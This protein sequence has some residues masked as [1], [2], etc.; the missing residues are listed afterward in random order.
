M[1]ENAFSLIE[2][3]IVILIIGILVAG[4]TQGSRLV[5]EMKLTSAKTQTQSAPV[6]SIKD[7]TLWLDS[8]SDNAITSVTNEFNPE[9]NDPISSWNDINPNVITKINATQSSATLRP[10]YSTNAMNGLPAI[11][12]DG[13]D[14]NFSV[15]NICTQNF[16][17]F[18]VTKTSVPGI[19]SEGYLGQI[20]LWGDRIIN[21]FDGVPLSIGGGFAKTFNG[22][23]DSTLTGT[24]S[25]S[26]NKPHLLVA[27]RNM[28]NGA[29]AIYVDGTSDGADLGGAAGLVLNDA[30]TL[31]IGGNTIDSV[32]LDGYI[33]E[34][35]VFDRVLKTEE[36][37]SVENYLGKKWG[38][39]IN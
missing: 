19:D 37:K 14:D 36:R 1:R 39:K 6:A 16:T 9:N 23:P 29:R 15:E 26:D 7:L 33:S 27:T 30:Q 24:I 22:N 35:I 32:Y 17:V 2:L 10:L 28:S 8:V 21:S 31:L 34:I 20:I 5:Y 4:V 3:S 13:S 25:V 12:F 11:K 18:A 38:I